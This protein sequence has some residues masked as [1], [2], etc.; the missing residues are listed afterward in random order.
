MLYR[1]LIQN[2]FLSVPDLSII[3]TEESRENEELHID[4][5]E[6]SASGTTTPHNN[7]EEEPLGDDS[8]NAG[9]EGGS[10]WQDNSVKGN[11]F[12]LE[13]L[14]QLNACYIIHR[15]LKFYPCHKYNIPHVLN[16]CPFFPV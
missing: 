15:I 10:L 14:I 16:S 3:K 4:I 13:L 1:S 12:S 5:P 6:E 11:H 7:T 2:Y 9:S 8:S